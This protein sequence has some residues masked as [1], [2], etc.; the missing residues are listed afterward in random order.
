MVIA[1]VRLM[2]MGLVALG[3][4]YFLVS[5]YSRSVRTEKLEAEWEE[6]GRPGLRADY[7]KQG[8]AEYDGSLRRK[9]ILLVVIVP[10]ILVGVMIYTINS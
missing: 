3:V 6:V 4:L 8:L 9:L 10:P 5:L 2:L 7:V 1:I